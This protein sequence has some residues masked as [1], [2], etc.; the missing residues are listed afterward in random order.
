MKIMG[1]KYCKDI[2]EHTY[3]LSDSN[4]EKE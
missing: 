1:T 4:M 2:S 3:S